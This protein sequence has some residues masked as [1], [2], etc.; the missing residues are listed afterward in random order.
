[1]GMSSA[2]L[3]SLSAAQGILTIQIITWLLDIREANHET[4]SINNDGK[5][6]PS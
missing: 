6:Y 1:M 4:L 2:G 5:V 3:T